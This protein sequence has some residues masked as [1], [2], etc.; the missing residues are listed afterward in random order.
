[1]LGACVGATS[2]WFQSALKRIASNAA[3]FDV[4]AFLTAVST[5][6]VEHGALVLGLVALVF[7]VPTAVYVALGRD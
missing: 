4:A 2:T 3:S 5:M 7:L 1:L 6:F